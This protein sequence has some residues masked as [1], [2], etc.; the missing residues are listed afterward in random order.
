MPGAK[1]KPK[2]IGDIYM[3]KIINGK[4][5][6][7][8]TASLICDYENTC[9]R[10]DFYWYSEELYQK[11]T[12]EFFIFGEGGPASPYSESGRGWACGSKKIT[13]ISECDAQKFVEKNGSVEVYEKLWG[14]VEE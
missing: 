2:G 7:T 3:R 8:D 1:T 13:P 4:K 11:K 12:G 6:D 9:N 10:T 14:E 5:Y